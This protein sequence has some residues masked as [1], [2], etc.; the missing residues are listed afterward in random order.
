VLGDEDDVSCA[1]VAIS[2]PLT[3][4]AIE[5]RRGELGDLS[6]RVASRYSHNYLENGLCEPFRA[7]VSHSE[8]TG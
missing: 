2:G 8:C 4:C 7:A 3:E 6:V 1:F 5:E